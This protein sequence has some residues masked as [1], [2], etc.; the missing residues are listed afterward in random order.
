M[1]QRLPCTNSATVLVDSSPH[2]HFFAVMLRGSTPLYTPLYVFSST[3][4]THCI[5][6]LNDG[7]TYERY[8]ELLGDKQELVEFQKRPDWCA[9]MLLNF[10]TRSAKVITYLTRN[11]KLDDFVPER[12]NLRYHTVFTGCE[13][14]TEE[15][16]KALFQIIKWREDNIR[17]QLTHQS[18]VQ[19]FVIMLCYHFE[20]CAFHFSVCTCCR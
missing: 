2:A 6:T 7:Q 14:E 12:F 13:S 3:E 18:S 5:M 4:T 19:D 11:A 15:Q 10:R 9:K 1:F 17:V 8:R 16:R 20:L